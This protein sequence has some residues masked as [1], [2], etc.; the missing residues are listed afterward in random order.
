MSVS[1]LLLLGYSLS[2]YRANLGSRS[3]IRTSCQNKIADIITSAVP[4][5]DPVGDGIIRTG[6]RSY[7]R[8]P[9]N[10]RKR[11]ARYAAR[12]TE[13][14]G[15]GGGECSPSLNHSIPLAIDI[16]PADLEKGCIVGRRDLGFAQHLE[17]PASS[18]PDVHGSAISPY[19]S[20]LVYQNTP[21]SGDSLT[22]SRPLWRRTG[23]S[24]RRKWRRKGP[25]RQSNRRF[26]APRGGSPP[27]LLDRSG[28]NTAVLGSVVPLRLL[29]D[30]I[31]PLRGE[32]K[33]DQL[34][35]L[36]Y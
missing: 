22:P 17:R 8:S 25:L 20:S 10:L 7:R 23:S 28:D 6:V 35:R 13:R 15:K 27:N 3:Y 1:H 2:P 31:P 24:S 18:W 32:H 21:S 34:D 29:E 26:M 30:S 36:Y 14:R 33:R 5:W 16:G 11:Y 9:S 12:G 19:L 4:P